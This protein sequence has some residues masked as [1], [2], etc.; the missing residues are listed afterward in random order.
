MSRA[1]IFA[2]I[3]ACLAGCG[4]PKIVRGRVVAVQRAT[5]MLD[6]PLSFATVEDKD[7]NYLSVEVRGVLT[8]GMEICAVGRPGVY[9]KLTQCDDKGGS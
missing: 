1:I 7:G 8:A 3:F 5:S 9:Y 2:M 6:G 4:E